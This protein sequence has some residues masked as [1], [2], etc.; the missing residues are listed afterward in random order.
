M[1]VGVF[2]VSVAATQLCEPLHRGS[3][4]ARDGWAQ[5]SSPPQAF[6]FTR[7]KMYRD[8]PLHLGGFADSKTWRM[9][10]D[11]GGSPVKE[12]VNE[13]NECTCEKVNLRLAFKISFVNNVRVAHK[14]SCC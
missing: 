2:Q 7:E 4:S 5:P 10:W 13:K 8:V 12:C 11:A 6:A 1:C 3:G 14:P 9:K